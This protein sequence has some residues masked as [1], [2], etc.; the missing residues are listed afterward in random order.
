MK[1]E[2]KDIKTKEGRKEY[3]NRKC[4]KYITQNWN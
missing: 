2:G 1:T 4:E 3:Q